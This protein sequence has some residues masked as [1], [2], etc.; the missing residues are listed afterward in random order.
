[1][2]ELNLQDLQKIELDILQD[3]HSFCEQHNIVY[4]IAYGS[5]IG[6][7]RHKGFIPWDDDIDIIMPRPDF[8]RFLN[9][10][11][12]DKFELV[13]PHSNDSYIAYGRVCDNKRTISQSGI[14]W[15]SKDV[16]VWIDLFP[17]DGVSDNRDEF[18]MNM[19]KLHRV[20]RHQIRMRRSKAK[21]STA[22]SF[23]DGIKLIFKTILFGNA[24]IHA[25]NDKHFKK[26]LDIPF[27]ST[28][29]WSQA[30]CLDEEDREFNSIEDFQSTILVQFENH[31]FR[32]MNGYDRVLRNSYGDYM[33][34]PPE[35]DRCPKQDYVHFYWKE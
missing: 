13:S 4:S 16:G 27:G 15:C 17:V 30:V 31:K 3:V 25:Y 20:W 8:E 9:E 34:L 19:K 22:T 33:Q 1:M 11:K 2:R 7:I 6:A 18:S 28:S 24:N 14:P 29:H 23:W 26:N 5:L 21:I 12:S 10:Y 35:E 32:V